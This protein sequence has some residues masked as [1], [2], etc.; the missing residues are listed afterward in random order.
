M[1]EV[2]IVSQDTECDEYLCD[3]DYQLMY[4]DGETSIIH[5]TNTMP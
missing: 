4:A 1:F 5:T 2:S 3:L